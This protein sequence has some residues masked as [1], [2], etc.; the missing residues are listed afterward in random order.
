MTKYLLKRLTVSVITLWI[1][2]TVSFFLLRLLPGNPFGSLNSMD[3]KMQ[4]R[5]IH[6]YGLDRPLFEQYMS[7]MANLLQGNLGYSLNNIGQTVNDIIGRTFPYSMQL[8]MQAYLL[9]FPL[10]IFLGII[11]AMHRGKILD[12]SVVAFSALGAAIPVFILGT[13]LQYIFAI[14]L[15]I[16]P[17][18]QWKSVVHTILPTAALAIGAAASKARAMRTL[19]LEVMGED[20][21]QTARAKGITKWKVVWNHQIRN[22]ILPIVSTMGLEIASILMGSFVIEQIFAIP[23]LGAYYVTSIQNLDYTMTLGLTV[24]Y[25]AFVIFAN[26]VIDIIYGFIDPRIRIIES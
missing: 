9:S 4:E 19:M 25:S 11:A 7:Y 8:G 15:K 13:V 1:I 2:T 17:I 18:A 14:K 10:G 23:G 6:Y 3:P 26:L 20:Y 12:H 22:A 21:I 24:F 16:L 5:M